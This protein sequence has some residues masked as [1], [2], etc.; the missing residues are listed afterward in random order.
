MY[1]LAMCVSCARARFLLPRSLCPDFSHFLFFS[2]SVFLSISRSHARSRSWGSAS[3]WLCAKKPSD[4]VVPSYDRPLATFVQLSRGRTRV[5][6][7]KST[8]WSPWLAGLHGIDEKSLPMTDSHSLALSLSPLAYRAIRIF[9]EN[10]S[11]RETAKSA[12][13]TRRWRLLAVAAVRS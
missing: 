9:H 13:V 1:V 6:P 12:C 8:T 3:V 11:V 10:I 5:P 7:I 2:I 4:V